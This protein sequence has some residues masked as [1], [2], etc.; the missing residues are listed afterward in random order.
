MHMVQFHLEYYFIVNTIGIGF[1]G[2]IV[3]IQNTYNLLI[4]YHFSRL[5]SWVLHYLNKNACL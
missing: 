4:S 5:V 2:N 3:Q 1:T